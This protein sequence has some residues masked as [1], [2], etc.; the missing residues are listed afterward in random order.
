MQISNTSTQNFTGA[1]RIK[2]NEIKAKTEIP[3]LF[4]QGRQI[5][6]N[7]L[8]KGDEVIVVRSQYDKRIGKYIEENNLQGIEY[9][10]TITTKSGLDDEKPEGLLEL[11][12]DKSTQIIT[13]IKEICSLSAQQKRTP[14]PKLPTSQKEVEKISNALRLNFE[15]PKVVSSA[16][17]TLIRD[18]AKQRTIEVIM[19][20]KGT[21]YVYVRP[22]AQ[23]ESTTKCIIDG[24]GNIVKTFETPEEIHKFLKKFNELK[25]ENANIIIDK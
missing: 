24:Q 12:K 16:K 5:F 7:I 1:Y 15:Q 22:D 19:P 17:S 8:E 13:D 2:P 6:H 9:Y 11:I 14:K 20:N 3:T 25:Q 21:S 18:E 23:Y 10:P 4:T